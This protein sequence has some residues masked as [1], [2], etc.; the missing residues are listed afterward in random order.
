MD[1]TFLKNR[2]KKLGEYI[3]EARL[4]KGQTIERLSE[5][6]GISANKLEEYENGEQSPSLP[7]LELIAYQLQTSLEHFVDSGVSTTE[8]VTPI[9]PTRFIG[10]RQRIIGAQ[11]RQTR[12]A[13]DLSLDDLSQKT[14][15]DID[16]LQ[17]YEMG[18]APIPIPQFESLL[19]LL[20]ASMRD[21]QDK[22]G[23]IGDWLTKHQQ[24]NEFLELPG[25][26]RSFITKPVNLPYLQLAMRLSEMSVDKLRAVAEGL[27]E[28][29]L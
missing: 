12:D 15:I 22:H 21:F 27:L 28:I 9:N 10:I 11:L 26:I 14:A 23:P 13:V 18:M 19:S 16:V 5:A 7:E 8:D 1:P 24:I 25:E 29:T 6:T 20:N 4:S 3:R 17:S 2:A